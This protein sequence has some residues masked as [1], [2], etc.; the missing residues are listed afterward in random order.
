M[1]QSPP[2][3]FHVIPRQP[4]RWWRRFMIAA[5]RANIFLW[6]EGIASLALVAAIIATWSA[7]GRSGAPDDLLPTMQVSALL[8]ATLVPAMMLLVLIG[9][10]L[11]LR[12]AAGSTARLHVRLVFFFSMVAA[13]PTLLVAGFAAF[14]FQTGVD[15]WFSDESRGLMENANALAKNYYDANQRGVEQNTVTM[16]TDMRDTLARVPITDP[17]FP[18]FYA[19]QA[20]AREIS[21][22]AILQRMPDGSFR[23]AAALNLTKDNSPLRFSREALPRLDRGEL[24]VVVGS[25]ERIEA[26]AA[27]DAKSGVY[28]YNARTTEET[29]FNS[30]SRAQSIVTAYNRLTGSAR[31]LQLKFNIALVAVSLLLVSLAIWFGLRFAD[32]Q[33][34]PLTD[35]VGAA[36][37][38]GQ[39][40]FA[41]RLEGRTG[42]DEIGLL[43]R[44][45]NR[46]TAQLEKQ[47]Q[48]LVKANR[49][50]DDRRAFT[51]AV[52]ES[53][54]AGVVSVDAHSC[55]TLMNSSAQALLAHEG[56]EAASLIGQSL[57]MLSPELARVIGEGKERAVITHAKGT[58]L[59]TLAVKVAPGTG[60]GHVITFE[61]ITRQL[62]DQR[63]A[64]WSDVARRIAHEIKNPLTPIQLATE[65]LKRRYRT[66][67][68]DE[69]RDLFDELTS[70]IVRQ[71]GDLRTMVDEFS[72]FARLPKPVF[73]DE[74]AVDLVRQAVFLQ[75]VAH[76]GIAFAVASSELTDREVRCDRHQFGQAMTNVLKNAVEAVEARAAEAK[77]A[78]A[79]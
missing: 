68:G 13:V 53:V 58:E 10:R 3:V 9:R 32:R 57:G 65:R 41:L 4:P 17:D 33:V 46:M 36:R 75:E 40:N 66:Q 71:V 6:L 39:G 12:R 59:L 42:A 72:S 67:V 11:A 21:E 50:I 5:R 52:L 37:K 35:L 29:M 25:P 48:A 77:G 14:L 45:F 73:R 74:D 38:V 44:A 7:F 64:A 27:I 23:T 78:Y 24:A 70:T 60:G 56:E 16:A 49:Q 54:T 15:F 31:T 79:G 76:S 43:N 63:Q 34:Q 26:L 62:L 1:E 19:Y 47:T 2:R 18:D 51:E 20:Q 61:D 28:L 8:M 30:W 69:D 55:V 22:S